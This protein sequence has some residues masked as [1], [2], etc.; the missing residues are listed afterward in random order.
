MGRFLLVPCE[1][2]RVRKDNKH[3]VIK[4]RSLFVS[5]SGKDRPWASEVIL[6]NCIWKPS[7]QTGI[8]QRDQKVSIE[9]AGIVVQDG[10]KA[11]GVSKVKDFVRNSW[12]QAKLDEVGV[13]CPRFEIFKRRSLSRGSGFLGCRVCFSFWPGDENIFNG[14]EK[15]LDREFI[16]KF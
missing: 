8:F 16:I 15:H 12:R 14:N 11:H 5:I 3:L 6:I 1:S 13:F 4:W 10:S 9:Y 2:R 7:V